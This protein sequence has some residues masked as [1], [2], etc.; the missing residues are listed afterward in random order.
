[1]RLDKGLREVLK[2]GIKTLVF[3]E[4]R[5]LRMEQAFTPEVVSGEVSRSIQETKK[6]LVKLI[7]AMSDKER[8][9]LLRRMVR[10][11]VDAEIDRAIQLR[12]NRCVRCIHGRFYDECGAAYTCLPSAF[13]KV[14]AIGCD[15]LRPG[16]RKTCRR[17]VETASAPSLEDYLD[18]VNLLY[19]F[20]NFIDQIDEIW[21]D[22][23]TKP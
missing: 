13:V 7:R 4:V 11:A 8:A 6:E 20:R 18:E 2:L 3:Q 10:Q 16:I 5:H 19:E 21:K 15:R 9:P 23:L 1:M 12:R 22:Y 17:F 14:Q